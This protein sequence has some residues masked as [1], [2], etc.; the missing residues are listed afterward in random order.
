M[1]TAAS[2]NAASAMDTDGGPAPFNTFT[3]DD[4]AD[5]VDGHVETPFAIEMHRH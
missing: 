2:A 1:G 4:A 3:M 5:I